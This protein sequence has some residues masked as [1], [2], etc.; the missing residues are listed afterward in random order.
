MIQQ[1]ACRARNQLQRPIGQDAHIQ[2]AADHEFRQ[3]GGLAGRLHQCR[4]PGD[5]RRRD[6]FQ[7]PPDREVEGVDMHRHAL[8]GRQDMLAGE[9]GILRQRLDRAIG[10]QLRIRQFPPR[11]RGQRQKRADTAFDIDPAIGPR[12]PGPEA[13]GIEILFHLQQLQ[14]DFLQHQ[15]AL[16]DG[17]RAQGPPALPAP[18]IQ[19]RRMIEARGVDQR[20]HLAGC[21]IQQRLA[22]AAAGPPFAAEIGLQ[23]ARRGL[24]VHRSSFQPRPSG[25]SASRTRPAQSLR[26]ASFSVWRNP[27]RAWVS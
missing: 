8:Q 16:M 9:A 14:A 15:R 23:Q 20:H 13:F 25:A 26:I 22:V 1:I 2:D 6:L 19:R 24:L 11:L 18:V 4:H 5:Q 27:K 3:I 12:R 7:H 17:H 10:D 21:G